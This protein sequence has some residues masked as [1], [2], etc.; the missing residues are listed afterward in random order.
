MGPHLNPLPTHQVGK[1]YLVGG[2][3]T[4]ADFNVVNVM[5][6]LV[7]SKFDMGPFPNAARYTQRIMQRPAKTAKSKL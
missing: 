6:W 7:G 3:F 2:R 5:E 1:D 4:I